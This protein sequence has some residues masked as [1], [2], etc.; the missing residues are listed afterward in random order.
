M[1]VDLDETR[2]KKREEL[3]GITDVMWGTS[4]LE[5]YKDELERENMRLRSLLGSLLS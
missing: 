5:Y 4:V 3:S 2:A 1:I